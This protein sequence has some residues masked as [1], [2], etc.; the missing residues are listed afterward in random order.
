MST[1]T[2]PRTQHDERE[3]R[4]Q[5]GA[6]RKRDAVAFA[7]EQLAIARVPYDAAAHELLDLMASGAPK[8]QEHA[9]RR[10]MWNAHPAVAD[11][12]RALRDAEASRR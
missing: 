12:Q 6:Q 11:A 10:R 5:E 1:Q 2:P 7:R 9:A 8:D 3:R 4:M